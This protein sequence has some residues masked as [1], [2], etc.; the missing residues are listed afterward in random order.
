[1]IFRQHTDTFLE[2]DRFHAV[3][4]EVFGSEDVITP[5]QDDI[6]KNIRDDWYSWRE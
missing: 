6:T 2:L 4:R 1:V 5:W 3:A